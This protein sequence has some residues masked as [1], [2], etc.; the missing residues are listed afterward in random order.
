MK[1]LPYLKKEPKPIFFVD[2]KP[3]LILGLQWDCNSCYSEV[4]MMPL[5]EEA[6]KLGCNTA[7]TPLYWESVEPEFG[8][9]D[10]SSVDRR[11]EVCR[12]LG[13]K[14]VL[15]WF[16][17]YKNAECC[18]A[19]S[20][21][22]DDH[23]TYPKVI[24]QDGSIQSKTLCPNWGSA[25]ER[26]C[27]A[28][29]QLCKHLRETD[30]ERTVILIQVENESGIIDTPRCYCSKCNEL[31]A[32]QNWLKEYGS[33]SDEAF[34]AWSLAR[35]IDQVALAGKEEYSIPMYINSA[36]GGYPAQSP[37]RDYFSAGPIAR[38]LPIWQQTASHIDFIA[39]DIYS[40]SYPAFNRLCSEFKV[41]N[42]PL[43]IAETATDFYGRTE[44]NV[45]YAIGFY[46]AIGFDPWAIDRSFPGWFDPPLVRRYDLHWS[47]RALD[48]RDSYIAIG[49]ALSQVAL[50]TG[51]QRL[52]TFV[53]EEGDRGFSFE[54]GGYDWR[55]T[56][57]IPNGS[58]RGMV[59]DEGKGKFIILGV[60]FMI[61]PFTPAPEVKS[62]PILR[63]ERGHFEGD[64]WI[65]HAKV[66]RETGRGE[67]P[68]RV[69][70]GQ[71]LLVQL[72]N[73]K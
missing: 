56:Y 65:C 22:R 42:N 23:K 60:N 47:S 57:P 49:S 64:N 17:G 63:V 70:E 5:F 14:L 21:I 18:Y 62:V 58:G 61:Q 7:V 36:L 50:S 69:E 20:Y 73:N 25:L 15:L 66:T 44:R 55:V 33:R 39:P 30:E 53:Q 6:V 38:W 13:L 68:I 34:A 4:E 51:T 19:P 48:L 31:F 24:R 37:G 72:E 3:F 26:D 28:F 29:K 43:Y 1:P 10:F 11:I 71:A 40:P 27:L 35:Y 12:K 52:V 9:Y 8:Q 2:G 32:Q 67:K 41:A 45:F 54:L 59:I 16:G 46:G